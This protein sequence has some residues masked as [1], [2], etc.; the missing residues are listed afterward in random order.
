MVLDLIF[1]YE[2]M[3][4]QVSVIFFKFGE[5]NL[6]AQLFGGF[7]IGGFVF[8]ENKGRWYFLDL[9]LSLEWLLL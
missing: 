4:G 1:H 2:D 5:D 7:F 8:T 9:D 6:G 3:A